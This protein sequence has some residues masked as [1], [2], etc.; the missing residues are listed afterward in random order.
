MLVTMDATAAYTN[1][2]HEDGT[3]CLRKATDSTAK[4]DLIVKLM[5]HLLKHNL[6]E[7]NSSTWRQDIGTAMGV[8]PAPSYANINLARRIDSRIIDL[9]N[10]LREN[11][12]S[13][14]LLY[15][16]LLDDIFA[17][18]EGTTKELHELF[19]AINQI[20]PT[21]KLTMQHTSIESEPEIDKC[22]CETRTSIPFLDTSCSIEGGQIEIDLYR[23]ETDRNQY[24]LTSSCHP[25]GCTKNI[26]YSRGLQI[27]RTCTNPIIRDKRLYEL[28]SLLSSRDYP[29]RLIDS[30]LAKARAVPREKAL[31]RVIRKKQSD[32][33][34]PIF[35]VRFDPRLPSITNMQAKHWRS[36]T[37]DQ[38]MAEVF[39]QPPL[40]AFR[41]Q[42]NLKD[43]LIRA[44]VPGDRRPHRL[45]NGM[46]KCGRPCT[47]CPYTRPNEKVRIKENLYWTI[48]IKV[49]CQS[50]NVIYL[51]ECD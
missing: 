35:A 11:N 13:S 32:K 27:V 16:R 34:R 36:M 8:H 41:R 51:L 37:N 18:F 24:L 50:F 42:N 23:K 7:F 47:A 26:P 21:L 40:T 4:S 45:Q 15:K 44:K 12:E 31:R 14:L 25:I 20:H 22:K 10:A 48:N 5:E 39:P 43:L 28:K 6:F 9:A 49:D 33:K 2:P 30:A 29:V 19:E 17:I 3:E 46:T 38:Y 1:R